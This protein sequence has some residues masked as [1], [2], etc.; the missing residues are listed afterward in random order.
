MQSGNKPSDS[1][2]SA[3]SGASEKV[4]ATIGQ[5]WCILICAAVY[6][7]VHFVS[8]VF[9]LYFPEVIEG[10]WYYPFAYWTVVAGPLS[11]GTLWFLWTRWKRIL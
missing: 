7:A 6:G 8:G 1:L 11:M 9:V 10:T 5:L 2:A 4:E 3:S